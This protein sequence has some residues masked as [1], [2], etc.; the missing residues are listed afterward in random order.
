VIKPRLEEQLDIIQK[1]EARLI[2]EIKNL[3]NKI[4]SS[5]D[6]E[7]FSCEQDPADH[8]NFIKQLVMTL[9]EMCIR[10]TNQNITRRI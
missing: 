9:Y 1:Y 3:E 4:Y 2:Y 7:D 6:C 10:D 8:Q 5:P